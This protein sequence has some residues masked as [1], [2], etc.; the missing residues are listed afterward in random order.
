V[1]AAAGAVGVAV[2]WPVMQ[3]RIEQAAADARHAMESGEH[4][5]SSGLRIGLWSWAWQVFRT[6]PLAGVGAGGF[7]DAVD[8][9]PD[10]RAA[11]QRGYDD[12]LED[13]D[14]Y[15]EAVANGAPLDE[16]KGYRR[17]MRKGGK[18]ASYM[19]R[20]HAH[21][22]YL[23]SLACTGLTGCAIL[24]ALLLLLVTRGWRNPGDNLYADGTLL[25]LLTW[26]VG[27]QFDCYQLNS[28]LF[29]L[30]AFA[31]VLVV[32]RGPAEA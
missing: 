30:L 24:T 18:R 9:L 3:P 15:E 23:H 17:A 16:L 22:V 13:V 28:H 10:H 26:I 29:G 27:A 32:P 19:S 1:L 14:G 7:R 25:V 6:A 2:S 4:W 21:S 8:Q 20:D 11:I 5:T 12:L 31:L